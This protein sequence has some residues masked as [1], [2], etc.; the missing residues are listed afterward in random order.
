MQQGN[1]T[2][3][4]PI[5]LSINKMSWHTY[6]IKMGI[7]ARSTEIE[8]NIKLSITEEVEDN[9]GIGCPSFIYPLLWCVWSSWWVK[10]F[11]S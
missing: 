9:W 6:K 4:I 1:T 7:V 3:F 10:E 5:V 2:D 11:D 8:W